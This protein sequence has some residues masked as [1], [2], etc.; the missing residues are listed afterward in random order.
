MKRI[1]PGIIFLFALYGCLEEGKKTVVRQLTGAVWECDSTTLG[2]QTSLYFGARKLEFNSCGEF[3]REYIWSDM[4][5]F[6][7]W[8]Y[9]GDYRMLYLYV[10]TTYDYGGNVEKREVYYVDD[11]RLVLIGDSDSIVLDDGETK[12][13]RW[14]YSKNPEAPSLEEFMN[15]HPCGDS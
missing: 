11:K 13:M 2:D 9:D 1:L 8:E 12:Y 3:Y 5:D 4:R 14:Y 10:D 6:G 15:P 7:T